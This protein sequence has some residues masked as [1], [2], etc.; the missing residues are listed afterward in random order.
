MDDYV[1]ESGP[2]PLRKPALLLIAILL[3][4]LIFDIQSGA[5]AAAWQAISGKP[6]PAPGRLVPGSYLR[7][8]EQEREYVLSRPPQEQ[9]ERLMQAAVNH[10]EGATA[11]IDQQLDSWRGRLRNTSTWADLELQARYSNDLRV[12]AAAIGVDLIANNLPKTEVTAN[13]LHRAGETNPAI[14]GGNAFALGMLAN[15]GVEPE[16]V[17]EWLLKWAQDSDEQ[18]RYWAVEGLALIGSDNTVSDLVRIFRNDASPKV[19]ERAGV[20]L[21]RSGMLTREQRLTAVPQLVQVAG[22]PAV[23]PTTRGWVYQALREITD[24]TLPNQPSSWRDWYVR[25]ASAK[26]QQIRAGGRPW[27]VAERD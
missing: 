22:D 1:P 17:R 7:M 24:E 15:R 18:T 11:L 10:D 6:Q 23:D 5:L 8:S 20:A 9:A 13:L 26:V 4:V 3:A 19:R 12:R 14:R 25:S 27:S 2:R 21:A 16:Q